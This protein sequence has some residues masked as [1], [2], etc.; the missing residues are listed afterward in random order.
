[1]KNKNKTHTHQACVCVCVF[2]D[3]AKEGKGTLLI[4]QIQPIEALIVAVTHAC[5]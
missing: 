1:M 2:D 4:T 3:R 5:Q